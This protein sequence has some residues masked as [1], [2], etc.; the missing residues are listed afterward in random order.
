[1]S[2]EAVMNLA[3][4]IDRLENDIKIL[5]SQLSEAVSLIFD[6]TGRGTEEEWKADDLLKE[7][8]K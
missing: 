1:M 6:L 3:R 5:R 2:D 7:I 8:G 4:H